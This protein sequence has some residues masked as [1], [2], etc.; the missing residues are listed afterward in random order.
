M[1]GGGAERQ[2]AY[3]AEPL[4]DRGVSVVAAIVKG[5][6]HLQRFVDG[7]ARVIRADRSRTYDPRIVSTLRRI[8]RAERPDVVHTWLPQM[9]VVAGFAALTC[10]VPWVMSERASAEAYGSGWKDRLREMLARRATAIVANAAVG[11]EL[12]ASRAPRVPAFV[13]PNAIDFSAIEHA[14]PVR[15][16]DAGIPHGAKVVLTAGRCTRQKNQRLL[17][18]ALA[19]LDGDVF[20]VICGDGPLLEETRALARERGVEDR[21]RFLGFVESVWGWMK[22]ADV[23]VSPSWFEGHP[24]VVLEAMAARCPL[25]VSDIAPHRDVLCREEA[26]FIDPASSQDLAAAIRTALRESR[27]SERVARARARAEA[28]SIDGAG[29]AYE[30]LYRKIASGELR[31]AS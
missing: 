3:L 25:V 11:A 5:G 23:F 16:E 6:P 22:R 2:L 8:I 30:A 31:R 17:I 7:G 24:N 15:A 14:A 29:A 18:E 20:A 9:D 1:G 10:A 26:L 28:F 12:W 4:A 19:Q 27:S 21:V 13:I